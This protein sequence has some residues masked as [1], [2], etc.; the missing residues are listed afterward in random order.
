MAI[1][2]TDGRM[3]A[4]NG[5]FNSSCKTACSPLEVYNIKEVRML[6]S[7]IHS[8]ISVSDERQLVEQPAGEDCASETAVFLNHRL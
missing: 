7:L 1:Y 8:L 2:N 6:D 3:E 4:R 5:G